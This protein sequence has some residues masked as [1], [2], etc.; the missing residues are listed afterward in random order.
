M[1]KLEK[2]QVSWIEREEGEQ[3][4]KTQD[5]V[6]NAEQN[7]STLWQRVKKAKDE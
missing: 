6:Q 4:K 7:D 1:E 3:I 2:K 5:Y